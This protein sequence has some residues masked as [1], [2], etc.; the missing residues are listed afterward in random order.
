[1]NSWFFGCFC[2]VVLTSM[3]DVHTYA[4]LNLLDDCAAVRFFMGFDPVGRQH[5]RLEGFDL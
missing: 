3:V 5:C 2:E 4:T 1:M